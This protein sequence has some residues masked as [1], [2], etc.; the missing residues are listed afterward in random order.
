MPMQTTNEL[1]LAVLTA[2]GK[3]RN[4]IYGGAVCSFRTGNL[5]WKRSIASAAGL[6][7]FGQES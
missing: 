6:L 1:F 3:I 2:P 4:D 7:M 5:V